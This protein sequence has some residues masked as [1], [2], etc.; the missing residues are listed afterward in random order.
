MVITTDDKKIRYL[1]EVYVGKTHDYTL[2]KDIF[3][4]KIN[5]FSELTVRVDLGYQGFATD[6]VCKNAVIP[7][8]KPRNQELTDTEVQENTEKAKQRIYVEHTIG[9]IKKYHFLANRLRAKDFNMYNKVLGICA[10]LWNLSI[11]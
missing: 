4:P 3:P 11:K 7:H 8:K 9:G 1:S 2:L 6:Y 10:A 5:W